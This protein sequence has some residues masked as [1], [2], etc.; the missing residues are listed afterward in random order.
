[1]QF[2][3]KVIR[4]AAGNPIIKL[5]SRKQEPDMPYGEPLVVLPDGQRWIFRFVKIAVN[6]AA[7]EKSGGNYLPELMAD[8]FGPRAGEPG[9]SDYI[10]FEWDDDFGFLTAEPE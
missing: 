6:V 3:A 8:W 9:R 7:P 4:N 2:R 1:M 5:P 10:T